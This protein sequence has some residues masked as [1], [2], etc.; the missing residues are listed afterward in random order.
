MKFDTKIPHTHCFTRNYCSLCNC[1][2]AL[3]QHPPLHPTNCTAFTCKSRLFTRCLI[4]AF[5]SDVNHTYRT[6]RWAYCEP[7]GDR[8]KGRLF[9]ETTKIGSFAAINLPA[10]IKQSQQPFQQSL[11]KLINISKIPSIINCL[12]KCVYALIAES[13]GNK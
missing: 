8:V 2:Q 13:A 3:A 5:L 10:A 9:S 11:R 4:N 1:T 6:S 7:Q 12:Q